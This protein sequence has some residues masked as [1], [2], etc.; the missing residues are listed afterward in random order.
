MDGAPTRVPI[1]YRTGQYPTTPTDDGLAAPERLAGMRLGEY[2][3]FRGEID[4]VFV[5]RVAG[6]SPKSK[7][8]N[9]PGFIPGADRVRENREFRFGYTTSGA[10]ELHGRA[11]GVFAGVLRYSS[12]AAATKAVSAMARRVAAEWRTALAD[13][14]RA[15][16]TPRIA[17]LTGLPADN[18][19]VSAPWPSGGTRSIALA[20]HGS[21]VLV[22]VFN[23]LSA[24]RTQTLQRS[25]FTKLV[26][27]S[28]AGRGVTVDQKQP[29]L[30]LFALTVPYIDDA[31]PYL[32]DG[33]VAGPRTQAQL[34]D[35]SG[36]EYDDLTTGGVDAIAQRA[37]ALYRARTPNQ[38]SALRGH[39]EVTLVRSDWTRVASPQDL[40][41]VP[42]Y[43]SPDTEEV[44]CLLSTDRYVARAPGSDLTEAQQRISAQVVLLDR[45]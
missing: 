27:A 11:V 13:A 28:T 6:T 34:A 14:G 30:D 33:T 26:A 36:A 23:G 19:V 41:G 24:S 31:D 5:E 16:S 37:T 20:P 25:T 18:T 43:K 8:E 9:L 15:A 29:N 22:A 44:E 10:G 17:S 32:Y 1:E 35:D 2:I 39:F 40:P 42:C 21:D 45:A 12:P 3:P 7:V 38:A 4:P